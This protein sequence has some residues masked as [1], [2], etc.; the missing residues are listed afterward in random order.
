MRTN[1]R[2]LPSQAELQERFDYDPATGVLVW[3]NP[4]RNNA[5][6]KGKQ[7]GCVS[8]DGYRSV[9]V[10]GVSYLA[11][12]LIWVLVYG[13][14]PGQLEVD[15]KD[16]VR[17]NNSLDNL[18]LATMQQQCWNQGQKEGTSS[19]FK[20]VSWHAASG[21]WSARIRVDRGERHLGIFDTQEEAAAAVEQAATYRGDFHPNS[22]VAAAPPGL[23]RDS[24]P[25]RNNTSGFRGVTWN[26]SHRK[27][28]AQFKM[29]SLGYFDTAEAAAEAYKQAQEASR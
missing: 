1:K 15:H 24:R 20:G 27:W 10:N 9:Y 21:G 26:K 17:D 6:M 19:S 25:R 18:R 23:P 16:R 5:H 29:R 4:S 22:G 13:E 8:A 14:D 28:Q 2:A 11:H 7:A 3:R 12:R